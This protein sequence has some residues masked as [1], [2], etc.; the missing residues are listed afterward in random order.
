LIKSIEHSALAPAI[1]YSTQ[2]DAD[3]K[4]HL[5]ELFYLVEGSSDSQN[6]TGGEDVHTGSGLGSCA[7][8]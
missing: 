2:V 5:I 4:L 7:R 3:R 8:A 1:S 6:D